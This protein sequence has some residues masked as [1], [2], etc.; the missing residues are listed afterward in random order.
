M[1]HF[2]VLLF[3]PS[4][5]ALARGWLPVRDKTEVTDVCHTMALLL[6]ARAYF[7]LLLE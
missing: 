1:P 2:K 4:G 7:R 3:V 5:T 6:A